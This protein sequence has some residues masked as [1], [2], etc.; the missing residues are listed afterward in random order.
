MPRMSGVQFVNAARDI[1]PNL[2]VI[3]ITGYADPEAIPQDS[4]PIIK[5][6]YRATELSHAVERELI[7]PDRAAG[8]GTVVPLRIGGAHHRYP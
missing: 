6:P 2:R 7:K 8:P 4:D 1:Q 3:Y 5:K